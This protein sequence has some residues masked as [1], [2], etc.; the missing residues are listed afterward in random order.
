M[1]IVIDRVIK[2]IDKSRKFKVSRKGSFGFGV[3]R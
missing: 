2:N 1:R 3:F